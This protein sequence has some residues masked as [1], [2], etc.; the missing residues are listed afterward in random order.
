M[1]TRLN[2]RPSGKL[3]HAGRAIGGLLMAA[4]YATYTIL[5]AI[6]MVPV[7]LG[8]LIVVSPLIFLIAYLRKLI[9]HIPTR[10]RS[11]HKH[12]DTEIVAAYETDTAFV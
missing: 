2:K 12:P 3:Q 8:S 1:N 6:L 9:K 5:S 11:A 7:A 10:K 4:G